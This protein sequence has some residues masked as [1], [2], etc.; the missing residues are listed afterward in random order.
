MK[1]RTDILTRFKSGEVEM[2]AKPI[3]VRLPKELD[4]RVRALPNRTEWLRK[5]IEQ[6]IEDEPEVEKLKQILL[7][8]DCNFEEC[9]E[10]K[11]KAE[12][13]LEKALKRIKDLEKLTKDRT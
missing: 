4:E 13:K 5:V 7:K 2:A 11:T 8:R 3:S 9:W 12:E 6:A 10:Q 1:L